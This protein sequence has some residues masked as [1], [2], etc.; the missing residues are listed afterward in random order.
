MPRAR[1]PWVPRERYRL[2]AER[3]TFTLLERGS[4]TYNVKLRT[5]AAARRAAVG[6]TGW[7]R[8]PR[9]PAPS[10]PPRS[11]AA[12][13]ARAEL[14]G[15][16]QARASAVRW[17]VARGGRGRRSRRASPRAERPDPGGRL[18]FP[19]RVRREPAAPPFPP[20]VRSDEVNRGMVVRRAL[21]G[22]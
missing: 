1:A 10:P 6:R 4:Q 15:H 14:A 21:P 3:T 12:S 8:R 20:G 17:S 11:P 5:P 18:W 13:S 19:E 22:P 7:T 16:E 2:L 9:P